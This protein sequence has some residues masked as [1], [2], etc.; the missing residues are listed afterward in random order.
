M[1]GQAD[2]R[3]LKICRH[4]MA[5]EAVEERSKALTLPLNTILKEQPV[6]G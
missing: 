3:L 6:V 5:D 1:H 4:R 2:L